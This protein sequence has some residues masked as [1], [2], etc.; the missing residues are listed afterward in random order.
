M[1][2]N[3]TFKSKLALVF[4]DDLTTQSHMGGGPD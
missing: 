3:N 1:K 2:D 4:D